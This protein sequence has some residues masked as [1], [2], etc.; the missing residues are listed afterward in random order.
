MHTYHS[1]VARPKEPPTVRRS[2]PRH[3]LSVVAGTAV[4]ALALAACTSNDTQRGTDPQ[5]SPPS[6]ALTVASAG[7]TNVTLPDLTD[8]ATR[9]ALACSFADGYFADSSASRDDAQTD[10]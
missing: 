4:L 10:C 8:P 1:D 6:T 2:W 5:A 9:K 3:Q 7:A